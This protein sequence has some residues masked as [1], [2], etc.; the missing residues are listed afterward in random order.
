[1]VK[2]GTIDQGKYDALPKVEGTPV[3]VTNEQSK[4]AATVLGQTWAK[5]VG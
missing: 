5:A 2:A 3:V 4:K 1:M